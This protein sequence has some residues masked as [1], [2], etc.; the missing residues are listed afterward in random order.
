MERHIPRD[1]TCCPFSRAVLYKTKME[2]FS[3]VL[4]GEGSEELEILNELVEESD[5]LLVTGAASSFMR[6]DLNRV[7]GYF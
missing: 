2:D 6:R 3:V 5:D 7:L 1:E 4:I